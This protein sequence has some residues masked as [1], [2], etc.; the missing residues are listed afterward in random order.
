MPNSPLLT[1]QNT[2]IATKNNKLLSH[3]K[4]NILPL[5]LKQTLKYFLKLNIFARLIVVENYR[6]CGGPGS[7]RQCPVERL[8]PGAIR[9]VSSCAGLQDD[10]R[11][12][13]PTPSN[14]Y[15]YYYYYYYLL[16]LATTC[17][18]L[19]LATYYLPVHSARAGD[20]ELA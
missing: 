17:Y 11:W 13:P 10:A 8:R 16:L 19:L 2:K 7:A 5:S 14:Y 20:R 9:A 3:R 4:I 6:S 12:H 1:P 18:Y 15:Y